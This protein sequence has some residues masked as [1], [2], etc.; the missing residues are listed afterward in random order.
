MCRVGHDGRLFPWPAGS[1]TGI[2]S[3]PGTDPAEAIKVVLGELPDL[4]Y[5]PELPG[6]GPG[7]DLIGR[8]AALLVDLPV[9]TTAKGW[10]LAGRPG[11]DLRRAEGWLSADLDA[12]TEAA[13]A[14]DGTFKIQM[15]GPWTLAAAL[16][17]SRSA[18]PALADGGAVADL[19][20]S[21]AEGAAAHTD[22][23]RQRLPHATIL[24]Q[25]D[26]SALPGVLAGSLPTA[27]G[28]N[29]LPAVDAAAVSDALRRVL[30]ATQA[31]TVLHCCAPNVPF[32]CI[33]QSGTAAVAF[34]LDLL[35]RR[36]D[37]AIGE[38]AEAGIGMFAGAVPPDSESGAAE[39]AGERA[40]VRTARAVIGLWQRIGLPSDRLTEQVVVTPACGLASATPGLARAVLK[41]CRSAARLMPELI[42]EEIG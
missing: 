39:Q 20:D 25:L 30:S 10:R 40:A 1:A 14:F 15:C 16:E 29:R 23:V 37:D 27:S 8:T 18:E 4:P 13:E 12:I 33:T 32:S 38:A 42:E 3:M 2:G 26:E 5:L 31:P 35:T 9:E 6:R 24:V 36:D 28:L 41:R 17:L 22:R 11:R 34:D 7:A 19:I 21:L